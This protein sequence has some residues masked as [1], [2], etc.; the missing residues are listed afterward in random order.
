MVDV[1]K[2][3]R[4]SKIPTEACD[5]LVVEDVGNKEMPLDK[6]GRSC[7]KEKRCNTFSYTSGHCFLKNV[8]QHF[9]KT[10]TTSSIICGHGNFL[11]RRLMSHVNGTTCWPDQI[12][13]RARITYKEIELPFGNRCQISGS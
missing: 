13:K 4:R 9:N 7:V 1:R 5:F 2:W 11:T 8:T 6:C 3:R 12:E 10:E